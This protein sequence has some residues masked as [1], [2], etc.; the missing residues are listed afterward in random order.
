MKI[1]YDEIL[2]LELKNNELKEKIRDFFIPAIS[3]SNL[4]LS[5]MNKEIYL[6][7][8]ELKTR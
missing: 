6:S 4:D 5:N 3:E 1:K 7:N 8:E 2:V